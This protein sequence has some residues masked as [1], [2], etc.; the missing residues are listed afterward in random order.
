M[1]LSGFFFLCF[2]IIHSDTTKPP[3]GFNHSNQ[4]G[5]KQWITPNQIALSP[6]WHHENARRE[7]KSTFADWQN[8]KSKRYR[9]TFQRKFN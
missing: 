6:P 3:N 7:S 4:Y 5:V 9:P 8:P 2:S 1:D